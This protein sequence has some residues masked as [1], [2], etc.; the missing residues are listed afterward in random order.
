MRN[1][2]F[3]E[4]QKLLTTNPASLMSSIGKTGCQ[5]SIPT[6]GRGLR[7]L[8]ETEPGEGAEVP[9]NV[10]VVIDHE[11]VC[12]PLEVRETKQAYEPL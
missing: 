9:N 5:L 10:S 7:V 12:V 11:V 2:T 4:L 3:A 8:V 6:D 1:A